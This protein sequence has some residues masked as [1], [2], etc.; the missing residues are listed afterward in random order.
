[1]TAIHAYE[2]E[3]GRALLFILESIP[4]LRL[5]GLTDANRLEERVATFSFRVKNKNPRAVAER[6]AKE[7]IYV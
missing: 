5:F 4:G 7:G 6:L 2:L 1:M 3:L